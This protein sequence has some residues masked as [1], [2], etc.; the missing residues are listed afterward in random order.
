MDKWLGGACPVGPDTV[1]E[2]ELRDGTR[3]QSRAGL[4]RWWHMDPSH[5]KD[6]V[7]FRA[8]VPVQA[9]DEAWLT[10][11]TEADARQGGG[12]HYKRLGVEPWAAMQAWMTPEEF[13]GFLRGN[14]IKYLA[15]CNLKGGDEDLRKAKHYV[16]K[17]VEVLAC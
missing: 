10:G 12:D 6:V 3:S 11:Q 17:L 8:V 9:W 4:L 15:R 2:F 5:P 1:V 16:D 7:A 14:A 13:R